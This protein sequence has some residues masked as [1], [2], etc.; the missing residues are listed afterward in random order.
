M[1]LALSFCW[2]E[3]FLKN[4]CLY[5]LRKISKGIGK[6]NF[7]LNREQCESKCVFELSITIIDL[8]IFD[9]KYITV[10]CNN[11]VCGECT[12]QSILWIHYEEIL[13]LWIKFIIDWLCNCQLIW[14]NLWHIPCVDHIILNTSNLFLKY[15]LWKV[16][17][18]KYLFEISSILK[19]NF[20]YIISFTS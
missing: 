16:S 14:K 12:K 7:F 9:R 20:Y 10:N 18:L 1:F 19:F 13:V 8:F 4:S 2:T 15:I 5:L 6:Q 17:C 3:K 11:I